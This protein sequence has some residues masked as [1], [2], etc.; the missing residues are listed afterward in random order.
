[1][2]NNDIKVSIVIVSW[3]AKKY[4]TQCI[5]SIDKQIEKIKA[6]VIVVDN[7]SND[8]S[9]DAVEMKFPR[10][11]IIRCNENYGFAK[12]NN[13]GIGISRGDFICLINSDVLLRQGCV[14]RLLEYMESHAD[15]GIL[16]PRTLNADGTLQKSCFSLPSIWNSLCRVS[17]LDSVF[18]WSR[19][20][21]RRLM[22]Y[23]AH[24]EIRNVEA[25]NGCFLLV[26]RTALEEV[27]LLDELFFMYGEDL[28]WCKRFGDCG[29]GVVY[30]PEAEAVHFGGASS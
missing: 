11:K 26:R 5:E 25:L 4:L 16:G 10:V 30:F 21:G 2:L 18:P 3:N 8:G 15:I 14:S 9:A 24:N 22:T 7:N 29:W 27:G 19:I 13:I 6:E 1:M 23:W 20:F 12:A 17:A 28:D